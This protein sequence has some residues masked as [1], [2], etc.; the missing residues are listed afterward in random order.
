M[1]KKS[2]LSKK[3][4]LIL[5]WDPP[6]SRFY[7]KND[8]WGQIGAISPKNSR[9]CPKNQICRGSNI[10]KNRFK[11]N[12]DFLV[13]YYDPKNNFYFSENRNIDSEAEFG[14]FLHSW[15]RYG[16]L[17]TIVG[18]PQGGVQNPPKKSK[19]NSG[20]QGTA[21]NRPG[22]APRDPTG[23]GGSKKKLFGGHPIRFY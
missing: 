12:R 14:F 19:K 3:A 6:K 21:G 18:F 23:Y 2:S 7:L 20:S 10:V 1:A 15:Y 8:Y 5:I 11:I 13:M 4:L 9:F 16:D 17:P 22:M